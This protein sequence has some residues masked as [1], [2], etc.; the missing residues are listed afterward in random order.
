MENI[1]VISIIL[2]LLTFKARY[3]VHNHL[4]TQLALLILS[5][6]DKNG[7]TFIGE[8]PIKINIIKNQEKYSEET[9]KKLIESSDV[10]KNSYDEYIKN[11]L[12]EEKAL[13]ALQNILNNNDK[14]A[15][16]DIIPSLK[17]IYDD[18]VY[19][20]LSKEETYKKVNDEYKKLYNKARKVYNNKFDNSSRIEQINNYD[21][22]YHLTNSK[23]VNTKNEVTIFYDDSNKF[24]NFKTYI[25]GEVNDFLSFKSGNV[26]K[27]LKS[28]K[29]L[30]YK[31]VAEYCKKSKHKCKPI[32][33]KSKLDKIEYS[34]VEEKITNNDEIDSNIYLIVNDNSKKEITCALKLEK[35]KNGNYIDKNYFKSIP[36]EGRVKNNK[37]IKGVNDI[38][39]NYGKKFNKNYIEDPGISLIADCKI[40]IRNGKDTFES[41]EYRY[42]GNDNRLNNKAL[43]AKVAESINIHGSSN[44]LCSYYDN[45]TYLS[46]EKISENFI[47]KRI[48]CQFKSSRGEIIKYI[49]DDEIYDI[50]CLAKRGFLEKM[51]PLKINGKFSGIATLDDKHLIDIE[52]SL[53][54]IRYTNSRSLKV[55]NVNNRKRSELSC[56]Y[57][58]L[59]IHENINLDT[60]TI[61]TLKLF[62]NM[63]LDSNILPFTM[64][65]TN[66]NNIKMLY[67]NANSIVDV[68][69][70]LVKTYINNNKFF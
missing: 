21:L 43:G 35:L 16:I 8:D 67:K 39:D 62:K 70:E 22:F 17:E 51:F 20:K 36:Y 12:S 10:F 5:A 14:Y 47:Q 30:L 31:N 52:N 61:D 56:K 54:F 19:K 32:F 63:N 50:N 34:I 68:W 64:D 59:K 55:C 23:L 40:K 48:S 26:R 57:K 1:L 9:I 65:I 66:I 7:M 38:I 25:S 28:E 6:G 11:G 37:Y 45:K 58:Q 18:C 3:S 13:K 42:N 41:Y 69:N 27:K 4:N 24:N 49:T 2:I 33:Q 44:I 60:L 15:I 46:L 53:N 29:E